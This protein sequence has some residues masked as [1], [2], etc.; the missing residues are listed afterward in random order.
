MTLS[1][2]DHDI[3]CFRQQGAICLRGV[4]DREMLS[5]IETGIE[6]TQRSPTPY[7]RVQSKPH[8]PG[9]F[10]TDYYMWR[11]HAEFARLMV[12]GPGAEIA[13]R[14]TGSEEIH[15]FYDGLFVKEPGTERR[16]DW[17]QDQPYYNVDGD[18]ICVI[19]IP[20][21]GIEQGAGLK[22]VKGSHRWGRW[23]QPVFFASERVLHGAEDRFEPMPDIDGNPDQYEIL[24]WAMEPGDCLVFHPLMIHGATGNPRKDRR[25]RAISTTWLGDDTVYGE[26]ADEVEP[27]IEGYSF[28]PGDRLNVESVFPKVWPRVQE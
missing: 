21:D 9:Y 18:Q 25:R 11:K 3:S 16:S 6:K 10:F 8:D 2:S 23:F 13:A 27:K 15:F 26:R 4:F 14:C 19:W 12:E 22:L 24:T 5:L 20:V 28:R 7:A 17:H 1:I